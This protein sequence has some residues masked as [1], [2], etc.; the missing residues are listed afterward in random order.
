MTL[1]VEDR[2]AKIESYG[3]AY[4][5][6]VESLKKFPVEMWNF[7]SE[8]NPW[9]IHEIIVHITDSEANSY[10]R[11]RRFIAEP[12]KEVLAY[13]E[14]LWVSALDYDSQSAEEA[15]EL[16]KVLRR[17]SY[18]LVKGLPA[19]TWANTVHHPE[20]GTMTFDEW[21]DTYDRHVPDH[22]EQMQKTYDEWAGST[23]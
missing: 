16:F 20:N 3:K 6:L 4:D 15:L 18:N 19:A 22:V 5:F 12:G 14:N 23:N 11:C 17:N 2:T 1:S 8:K 13:D 9:S 7:K 10:I 21:L